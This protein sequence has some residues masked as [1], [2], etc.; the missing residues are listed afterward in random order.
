[1]KLADMTIVIPTFRRP[2]YLQRTIRYYVDNGFKGT[3]L[4]G[5]SSSESVRNG[6]LAFIAD[7][8]IP[9]VVYCDCENLDIIETH[10]VLM[11][12]VRTGY[13]AFSGD[14]DYLVPSSIER[15]VDFL[16]QHLDY[17]GATGRMI[18][19]SISACASGDGAVHGGVTRFDEYP[20]PSIEQATGAE[21]LAFYSSHY[22]VITYSVFRTSHRAGYFQ[23]RQV[24]NKDNSLLAELGPNCCSVIAGKLKSFPH[25]H[26]LRQLGSQHLTNP[27][28]AGGAPPESIDWMMT[29]KFAES[30]R[31]YEGMAA[32]ELARVDLIGEPD[33][34]KEVK[35][36]FQE[37]NGRHLLH[38]MFWLTAEPRPWHA[39]QE[40]L[41]QFFRSLHGRCDRTTPPRPALRPPGQKHD[42]RPKV[43]LLAQRW[44]HGVPGCGTSTAARHLADTLSAMEE[45]DGSIVYTDQ[46]LHDAGRSSDQALAELLAAD[47]PDCLVISSQIQINAPRSS[48]LNYL[49]HSGIP[50]AL[51]WDTPPPSSFD[52]RNSPVS[53]QVFT[54]PTAAPRP[55]SLALWPP[56]DHQSFHDPGLERDLPVYCLSEPLDDRDSLNLA[57]RLLKGGIELHGVRDWRFEYF[58]RNGRSFDDMAAFRSAPFDPA[59]YLGA[60]RVEL[61]PGMDALTHYMQFG[62]HLGYDPNPL[63]DSAYYRAANPTAGAGGIAPLLHF[64]NLGVNMGCDPHPHFSPL[65]YLARHPDVAGR[66][67]NPLAHYLQQGV[68]EGRAACAPLAKQEHARLLKRSRIALGLPGGAAQGPGGATASLEAILCGAL[69]LEPE[70]SPLSAWF[71]PMV[72]YVAYRDEADLVAKLGHYLSHEEERVTIARNGQ[73]K[74]SASYTG[75]TFWNKLCDTILPGAIT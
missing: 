71:T 59:F 5:D 13:L 3:L 29:P 19:F 33:A 10:T 58:T 73:S 27:N 23:Y 43:L 49:K 16:E 28:Y 44:H 54:A 1:M 12:K 25:L 60:Y 61:P 39:D 45:I 21:R 56:V 62:W 9:N 41:R 34:R 75:Q 36:Q 31:F 4:I 8:K 26:V 52:P 69:L 32:G 7:E 53:R 72:D 40:E 18:Q 6:M 20:T 37:F 24:V 66:G 68:A 38:P 48:T 2:E 64:M 15:C 11:E 17:C 67:E 57:S 55:E 70:G 46:I 65:Y 14:D 30:Y 47:R 50:V 74:G 35:R 51:V 22:P 42:A 63:F